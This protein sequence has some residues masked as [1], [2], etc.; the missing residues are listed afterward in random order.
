MVLKMKWETE[1][2]A[3]K[4]NGSTDISVEEAECFFQY[5]TEISD[6]EIYQ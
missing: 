5:N 1:M 2:E 4:W 3:R 6:I